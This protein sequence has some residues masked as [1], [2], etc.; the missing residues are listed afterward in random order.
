[1]GRKKKDVKSKQIGHDQKYVAQLWTFEICHKKYFVH[2]SLSIQSNRIK[3]SQILG[4]MILNWASCSKSF[5]NCL[6][7]KLR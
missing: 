6:L 5:K 2:N 7:S 1:M 3:F 4:I